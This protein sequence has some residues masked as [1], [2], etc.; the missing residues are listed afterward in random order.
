VL[1]SVGA[2]KKKNPEFCSAMLEFGFASLG[3]KK[4]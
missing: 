1:G 2:K 3:E 4:C